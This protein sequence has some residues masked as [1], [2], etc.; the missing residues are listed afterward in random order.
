[1]STASASVLI[2]DDTLTVFD[3]EMYGGNGCNSEMPTVNCQYF[4]RGGAWIFQVGKTATHISTAYRTLMGFDFSDLPDH[5]NIIIDSAILRLVVYDVVE[6]DSVLYIGFQSLKYDVIEGWISDYAKPS[7]SSFTWSARI[8]KLNADT[9]LWQQGGAEGDDDREDSILAVSPP[10]DT[11][12]IYR[13]EVTNMIKYWMDSSATVRWCVL[14]DTVTLGG[15]RASARKTFLSSEYYIT[16]DK[17]RL[18]IY[19][20]A[21]GRRRENLLS[22]GLVK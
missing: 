13:I 22:G 19:Y 18:E 1:M 7:D 8:F 9:V 11:A 20:K 12:G 15:G 14:A 16:A 2:L 21:T 5:N 10:I 3:G 4:N 6:E 17:P